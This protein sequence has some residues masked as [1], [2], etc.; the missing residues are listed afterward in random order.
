MSTAPSAKQAAFVANGSAM[1][2]GEQE[3][4]D[5]RRDQLVGE[6]ERALHPGVG[7]PEVLA[8]RRG[9]G[10]SVLLAAS[11]NVSAV[12]RTNSATRTRAMLTVP[13]TIVATSTDQD[14]G[15]AEVHHDDHPPPVEPVGR[16][17]AQDA[18]QQDRQVFAEQRH[19]DEERIARLRRHEQRPGR[20]DDAVAGVVEDGGRQEPAEASA[21]PRRH[22]GF[23][24]PGRRWS[25]TG[26]RIPTARG[27]STASRRPMA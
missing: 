13:L 24:D 21:Q 17:A 9:P 23:E 26:G 12:P 1:P 25:C 15:A 16:R 4:A 5:R 20:E 18:E 22:D 7:D 27:R 8:L 3:G 6:Q 14:D 19:R 10:S 11:A 2:S